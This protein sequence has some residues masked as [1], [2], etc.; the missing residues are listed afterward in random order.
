M[1]K[2]AA[3]LPPF[4]V[5]SIG[6]TATL[7]VV[8]C[9]AFLSCLDKSTECPFLRSVL[10]NVGNF[11][12]EGFLRTI[13]RN[14]QSHSHLADMVCFSAE[15]RGFRSLHLTLICLRHAFTRT[16]VEWRKKKECK[17]DEEGDEVGCNVRVGNIGRG[18]WQREEK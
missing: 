3:F 18:E 1:Q 17:E 16:G 10:Y 4:I 11:N 14:R 12:G 8:Y 2:E 15:F 5:F 6:R 9:N 13:P 7:E